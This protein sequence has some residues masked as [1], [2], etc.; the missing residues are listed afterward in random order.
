MVPR[1]R[2]ASSCCWGTPHHLG[3]ELLSN[4]R[5]RAGVGQVTLWSANV[6]SLAA[7]WLSVI[8]EL[9]SFHASFG[10]ITESKIPCAPGTIL[11]QQSNFCCAWLERT[12]WSRC[13]LSSRF[14]GLKGRTGGALVVASGDW[15]QIECPVKIELAAAG[16][17]WCISCWQ[18]A[19]GC[20]GAE[21]LWLHIMDIPKHSVV[22]QATSQP[23]AICKACP[24]L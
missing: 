13:R 10:V 21:R 14:L 19:V 8:D 15:V 22:Q 16:T 4:S 1:W 24:Q 2:C 3:V 17:N 5:C 7:N 9:E 12:C 6:T 20:A 23:F 11:A 18:S